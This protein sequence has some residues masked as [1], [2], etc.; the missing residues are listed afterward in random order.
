MKKNDYLL[1]TAT[2]AYSFLFYRQNAG[3]NFLIFNIVFLVILLIRNRFVFRNKTWIWAGMMSLISATCVFIHSSDLS[4]LANVFS[5]LLVSAFSFN[6]ATSS[7]FSVIFSVFS[8]ASSMVFMIIDAVNRSQ[9]KSDSHSGKKGYKLLAVLIVVLLSMMF[10]AMYKDANPLFAENTKW[11]N[12]DF[13][14]FQWIVF[15][16]GGFILIYGLY[17]H[18]T[19]KPIE[20]WEN[21]LS[22]HNLSNQNTERVKQYEAERFSGLLLFVLL[23][24][25]LLLLNAGD[26]QTLYFN[27]GLPKGI[28]HSDFV[29]NGVAVIILSIVAAT[30]LM[31]FLYRKE[32][33]EVKNNK[34]LSVLIYGWII[35]NLIMLSSTAYRN[36]IYIHDYNF[37]YKRIGVYVWLM[38]AA[39]GLIIM[40]WKIN[41]Q[42]SNWFLIKTNVGVWF[43][44][45]TLSSCVNW[46]KM[47]TNYN[48]ANKPLQEID[49]HYLFSLSDTNI[50]ELIDITKHQDFK[51]IDHKLKIYTARSERDFYYNE[52]Y[53]ELLAEKIHFYL[54]HRINSWKSFDLREQDVYNSIYIKK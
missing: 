37:T 41:K 33:S 14:S 11:I 29:H 53:T 16:I 34:V 32:F 8:I 38:L 43:S 36:Q 25:M 12:L 24:L 44:V 4:I 9:N 42:K 22:L 18:R 26:I 28:T 3:I 7:I 48:L 50:P 27:G 31:M 40:F 20:N 46:D 35:Q 49:F 54:A 23:N 21:K 1:L 30:S 5:L 15:T 2:A 39:V 45:L 17:Y 52:S 13:I 6:P 51:Q 47:I 10:F 19:I